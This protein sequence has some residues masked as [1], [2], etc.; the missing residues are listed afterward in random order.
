MVRS[1]TSRSCWSPVHAPN[2]K[3]FAGNYGCN[4][5]SHWAHGTPQG[6]AWNR[7]RG[8]ALRSR[9]LCCGRRRRR[10]ALRIEVKRQKTSTSSVSVREPP[11]PAQ[12]GQQS[13]FRRHRTWGFTHSCSYAC[14]ACRIGRRTISPVGEQL[15]SIPICGIRG[16]RS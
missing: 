9:R 16:K 4:R 10:V 6:G 1:P 2:S 8:C 11:S 13:D 5:R 15:S 12:A 3:L 7:M 14:G